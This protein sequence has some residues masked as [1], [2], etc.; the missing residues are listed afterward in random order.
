M[1]DPLGGTIQRPRKAPRAV[2]VALQHV[3]G[4]ALGRLGPHAR[5]AAQGLDQLVDK[6]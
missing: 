4:Q 6:R 5:Q 1:T 3:Q 2:P